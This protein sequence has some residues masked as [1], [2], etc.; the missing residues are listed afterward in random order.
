M[1]TIF[2]SILL[3]AGGLSAQ[4]VK[5][6][7]GVQ[8]PC[9]QDEILQKQIDSIAYTTEYIADK[10]SD[11]LRTIQFNNVITTA[12]SAVGVSVGS[13]TAAQVRALFLILLYRY[14]KKAYTEDGKIAPLNRWANN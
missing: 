11:S 5:V 3:L 13:L 10:Q 8:V 9:T 7:N 1:R 12:Q 4:C 2:I 6:V 14:N